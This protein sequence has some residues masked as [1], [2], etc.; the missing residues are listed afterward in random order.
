MTIARTKWLFKSKLVSITHWKTTWV[1]QSEGQQNRQLKI[2]H[3]LRFQ[4]KVNGEANKTSI[5]RSQRKEWL[6]RGA[7]Y[8]GR[9]S[10]DRNGWI[11]AQAP[12]RKK[13]PVTT[14]LICFSNL[15]AECK[16]SQRS[17]VSDM[18]AVLS[19][20]DSLFFALF[21]VENQYVKMCLSLKIASS[22]LHGASLTYRRSVPRW[23]PLLK[24]YRTS[25]CACRY[26][27][28]PASHASLFQAVFSNSRGQRPERDQQ[29]W[30]STSSPD[31]TRDEPR[32]SRYLLCDSSATLNASFLTELPLVPKTEREERRPTNCMK[33]SSADSVD[34]LLHTDAM[35]PALTLLWVLLL[36][37]DVRCDGK[38]L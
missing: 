1:D 13:L 8:I 33:L 23:G 15:K 5:V 38:C 36:V 34:T 12:M 32:V 16:I 25:V 4:D 27:R 10:D 14:E 3:T 31:F 30:N 37:P 9:Y 18:M 24:R 17:D 2:I 6:S 22:T 29:P 11:F 19:F 28:T 21:S 20:A 35:D 7:P 26:A